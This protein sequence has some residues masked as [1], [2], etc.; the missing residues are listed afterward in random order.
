M[1][2]VP[3]EVLSFLQLEKE[4]KRTAQRIRVNFFIS[5]GVNLIFF[6]S[7]KFKEKPIPD[8]SRTKKMPLK[9]RHFLRIES[10]LF[11]PP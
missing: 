2:A 9:E 1:K 6:I 4:T 11:N 10:A 8:K 7:D 3:L 5:G